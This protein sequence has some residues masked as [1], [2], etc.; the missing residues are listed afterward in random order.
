MA[1]LLFQF[2]AEVAIRCLQQHLHD[3]DL[4]AAI[5]VGDQDIRASPQSWL[6]DVTLLLTSPA[7]PQVRDD[8]ALAMRL[9][10]QYFAVLGIG[11]NFSAGKTEAIVCWH[12]PGSS[13]AKAQVMVDCAA[14]IP[15]LLP[16]GATQS[17]RCVDDYVHL[18]SLRGFQAAFASDVKRRGQLARDV[19]RPFQR[20]I[21]CNR[22]LSLAERQNLL[23][24]MILSKFMHGAGTWAITEGPSSS[25]FQKTYM[26]FLRGSVR[27]LH[28][29]PCRRLN[30][31]QICALAGALTPKEALAVQRARLLSQLS[32]KADAYLKHCLAL[33]NAWLHAVADD[34]RVIAAVLDC[35][36]L[37]AYLAE[38]CCTVKWVERWPLDKRATANM[39]RKFRRACLASRDDLIPAALAKARAH[40]QVS[41]NGL[42]FATLK[43]GTPAP[44]SFKCNDCG[45]AFSGAARLAV[46]RAKK[47]AVRALASEAW[48]TVCEICRRQYW[49]TDRLKE[50]FRRSPS[51]A[52]AYQQAEIGVLPR[53]QLA[54]N[55]TPPVPLV[56]PSP[57]WATL[58]PTV[59][60]APATCN[61]I[62]DATQLFQLA[63]VPAYAQQWLSMA[64]QGIAWRSNLQDSE[65][66][67]PIVQLTAHIV[68]NAFLDA[69][70]H[71]FAVGGLA[72]VYKGARFLLGPEK[73][74]REA[75]GSYWPDL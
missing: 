72:T 10:S 52:F 7:A 51:C 42:V 17:L 28:G 21:L 2:I 61:Q 49:S 9:I 11:V 13:K 50:H 68:E 6:D 4:S 23:A 75:H 14:C 37:K 34:L 35:H 18:G 60:Q 29:V 22:H 39:L 32:L 20:R 19:Y 56:G 63:Q 73:P 1:D 66:A 30:A 58:R 26:S 55:A 33:E 64:E 62:P 5:R 3:R 24:G 59:D 54:P 71:F 45:R 47:H 67:R 44:M 38:A 53:M 31:P 12:G 41:A 15:V 46:H 69:E 25:V 57:W 8:V 16:D 74:L 27:P 48:G 65:W 36:V 43:A 70:E 40:D